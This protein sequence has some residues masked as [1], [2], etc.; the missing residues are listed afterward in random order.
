MRWANITILGCCTLFVGVML[1]PTGF[2]IGV[3]KLATS[4]DAAAWAQ[5]AGSVAAIFVAIWATT[6]Q[7]AKARQIQLEQQRRR[8]TIVLG[9]IYTAIVEA[10]GFMNTIY[11]ACQ[12]VDAGEPYLGES[13]IREMLTSARK[14][15]DEIPLIEVPEP[16]ALSALRMAR[17]QLT[18]IE[19][20]VRM[21]AIGFQNRHFE[22]KQLEIIHYRTQRL[23]EIVGDMAEFV[24]SAFRPVEASVPGMTREEWNAV[25]AD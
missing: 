6:H 1:I 3:W 19:P 18:D 13:A 20:L 12:H 15:L 14:I 4:R 7:V 24:P 2:Y 22:S 9:A 11:C 17:L 10:A 16:G 21:L 23:Y 8:E 25:N 5:A